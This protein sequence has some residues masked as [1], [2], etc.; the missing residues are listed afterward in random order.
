MKTL[1]GLLAEMALLCFSSHALAA[2]KLNV[3]L[4][5]VDD[6]RPELSCY[7]ASYI[8]SPSIDSLASRGRRFNRHYVQAPTCGASRYA[9]LTGRYGGTG[10]DALFQR[11]RS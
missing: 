7:G 9:L 8:H 10:N 4:I 3:L 2:E 6:L 5:C 11:A 1:I